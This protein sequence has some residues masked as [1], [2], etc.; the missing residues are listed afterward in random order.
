MKL[1]LFLLSFVTLYFFCGWQTHG[2][3][4]QEI[5]SDLPDRPL[6]N[7]SDENDT[8]IKK[9]LDQP[10]RYLGTGQQCHAFIGEDR[11]TVLKFFRHTDRSFLQLFETVSLGKLHGLFLKKYDPHY[12]MVSCLIGYED[13]RDRTGMVYLHLNKTDHLNHQVVLLDPV[14]VQQTIDLD[15]TEFLVQ[16][17]CEPA[18]P[19]LRR[20]YSQRDF[21]GVKESIKSIIDAAKEWGSKGIHIDDSVIRKNLGFCENR[22]I[23]FDIGSIQR[24]EHW[25]TEERRQFE[26]KK[27]THRLRRYLKK[28]YPELLSFFDQEIYR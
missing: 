2:F 24:E 6:W 20:L 1:V 12:V 8:G 27:A 18:L 22:A 4:F 10:F 19:H 26:V 25:K 16:E 7:I 9:R 11:K 21:V 3:R 14:G 5:L 23:L 28:H 15:T 17:C 13:L